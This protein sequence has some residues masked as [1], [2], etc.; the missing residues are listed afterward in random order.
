MQEL[1]KMVGI[2]AAAS[3]LSMLIAHPAKAGTYCSYQMAGETTPTVDY[4]CSAEG[5]HSGMMISWSDGV[6]TIVSFDANTPGHVNIRNSSA[7]SNT[8]YHYEHEK[9]GSTNH[10]HFWREAD[11]GRGTH[12]IHVYQSY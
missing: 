8:L 9:S 2:G 11:N 5:E 3:I 6:K 12:H 10:Y 4:G 1:L 7:A